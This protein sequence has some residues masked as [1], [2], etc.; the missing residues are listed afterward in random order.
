MNAQ[1]VIFDFNKTD[2]FDSWKI[3]NDDVMGGK[4][5][6]Y[7]SID[8]SGNAVFEGKVSLAN[9]GGFS[10]VRTPLNPLDIKDFNTVRIRLKGDGKTYQLRAKEQPDDRHSYVAEFHTDGTW[11][12]IDIPMDSMQATYRGRQLDIP[13]FQGQVISELAFLIG[14]NRAETFR[15]EIDYIHFIK[16]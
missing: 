16:R 5:E 2:N 12:S 15:L 14:N 11:Q 1:L 3:V 6:G 4:S 8:D 10:S 9:N 13:N 7:F